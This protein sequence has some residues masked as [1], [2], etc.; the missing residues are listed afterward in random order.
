MS[1]DFEKLLNKSVILVRI[2]WIFMLFSMLGISMVLFSLNH[3]FN[4]DFKNEFNKG[5]IP[6][7]FAIVSLVFVFTSLKV[8]E[9]FENRTLRSRWD[10]NSYLTELENHVVK[11]GRKVYSA[12]QISFFKT[13]SDQQLKIFRAYRNLFIAYVIQFAMNEA[14]VLFGLVLVV[15]TRNSAMFIPFA[16]TGYI[17]M[18]YSY[19]KINL[20]QIPTG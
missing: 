10:R 15:V 13:L 18:I 6:T 11:D 1:K 3:P 16:L 5:P 8:I 14:I 7:V 12:K 19:P 20:D 2:L 4:W 17:L 9:F